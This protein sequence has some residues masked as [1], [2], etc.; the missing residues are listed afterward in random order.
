M[1]SPETLTCIDG[2]MPHA[3][4]H[5]CDKLLYTVNS[6]TVSGIVLAEG[7]CDSKYHIMR[8]VCLVDA[9][10]QPFSPYGAGLFG[11]ETDDSP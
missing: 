1:P 3:D 4:P 6:M 5:V 10:W 11:V 2:V 9:L 8:R 7:E